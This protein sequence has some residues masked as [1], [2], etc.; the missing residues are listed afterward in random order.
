MCSMTLRAFGSVV[1]PSGRARRI[2]ICISPAWTRAMADDLQRR[3]ESSAHTTFVA[4]CIYELSFKLAMLSVGLRGQ[5]A[6]ASK[7]Y[8]TTHKP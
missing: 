1:V 7:P 2:S 5:Q 3:S 6:L 4:R 8:L